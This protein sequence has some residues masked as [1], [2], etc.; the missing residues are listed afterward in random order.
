MFWSRFDIQLNF[1]VPLKSLSAIDNSTSY[2]FIFFTIALPHFINVIFSPTWHDSISS[3]SN[4]IS[5]DYYTNLVPNS[6]FF[7]CLSTTS[8]TISFVKLITL[9]CTQES[10]ITAE[11]L[12]T[13]GSSYFLL[14]DYNLLHSCN[15]VFFECPCS[16]MNSTNASFNTPLLA[17]PRIVGNLGS[18]QPSTT[19]KSTK[20][21][22]FL[23]LNTVFLKFKR[24]KSCMIGSCIPKLDSNHLYKWCLSAYSFVRIQWVTPSRE[25]TTGVA[26]S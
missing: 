13:I 11:Y 10:F 26:K 22:S 4:N 23:L 9:T 25:S 17:M 18:A 21:L 8:V 2:G 5:L 15:V 1:L 16:C 24:L 14:I 19:F 7:W 12:G 6:L 20:S 3:F